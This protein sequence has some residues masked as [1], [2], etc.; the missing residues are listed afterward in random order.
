MFPAFGRPGDPRQ[1]REAFAISDA[2]SAT[3]NRLAG[4]LPVFQNSVVVEK[5]LR[6][7]GNK[8]ETC[9]FGRSISGE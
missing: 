5:Y 3:S 2:Q 1:A 7:F 4:P 6:S 8:I 9:G